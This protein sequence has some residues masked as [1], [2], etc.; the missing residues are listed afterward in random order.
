MH[1]ID[2]KWV[3]HAFEEALIVHGLT[4]SDVVRLLERAKQ[5]AKWKQWP[6]ARCRAERLKKSPASGGAE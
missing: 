1:K 5:R 3:R 2:P 4:N 6:A